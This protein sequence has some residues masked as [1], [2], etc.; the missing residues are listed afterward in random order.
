MILNLFMGNQYEI[1][2]K[3]NIEKYLFNGRM[4]QNSTISQFKLKT[5]THWMNEEYCGCHGN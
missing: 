5:L 4:S 3:T 1:K 2:I